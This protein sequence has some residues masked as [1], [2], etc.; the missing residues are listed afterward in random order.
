MDSDCGSGMSSSLFNGS[1]MHYSYDACGRAPD[2]YNHFDD[3]R[4]PYD[5][6][7]TESFAVHKGDGCECLYHG[8]TLPESVYTGYPLN[9]PGLY[10]TLNLRH[11]HAK[12]KLLCLQALFA[13]FGCFKPFF[14][15][16]RG[17]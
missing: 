3:P 8:A 12:Q 16:H 2:C 11:S 4:C 7:G 13:G 15:S 9:H 14:A 10:T 6:T 5:P 1:D 17:T